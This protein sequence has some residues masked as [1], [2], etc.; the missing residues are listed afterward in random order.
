MNKTQDI[1]R[2]KRSVAP[3][4]TSSSGPQGLDNSD[5]HLISL[6]LLDQTQIHCMTD[7]ADIFEELGLSQYLD[8]FC[9]HGFDTWDT[10]LDITES[11]L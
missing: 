7:L 6:D 4:L 9:E 8:T 10:I 5:S 3:Y 11:D 2:S 1:A